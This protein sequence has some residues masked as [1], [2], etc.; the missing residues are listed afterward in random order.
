M[1][2][3]DLHNPNIKEDRKMDKPGFI[4]N[5]RGIASGRDLPPDYLMGIFDRI[6]SNAISLKEDDELRMAVALSKMSN[7]VLG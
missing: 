3:T 4:R 1:L 5:N 6:K 7:R 2:N